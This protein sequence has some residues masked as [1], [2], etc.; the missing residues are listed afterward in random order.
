[1]AVKGSFFFRFHYSSFIFKYFIIPKIF[2]IG[3]VM[4]KLKKLV[5]E[6]KTDVV[7]SN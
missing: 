3:S 6:K 5:F 7:D 2:V 1:M 4:Q